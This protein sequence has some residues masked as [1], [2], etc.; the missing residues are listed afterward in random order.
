MRTSRRVALE[1]QGGRIYFD[2]SYLVERG[3][4]V[5]ARLACN[6]DFVCRMKAGSDPVRAI[7]K[8]LEEKNDNLVRRRHQSKTCTRTRARSQPQATF[9]SQP[10]RPRGQ[11]GSERQEDEGE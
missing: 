8:E 1:L 3:T 5:R 4:G 9:V 6:F 2:I 10:T 11:R 7:N